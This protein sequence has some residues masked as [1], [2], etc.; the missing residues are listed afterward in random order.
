[1]AYRKGSWQSGE[2]DADK[3]ARHQSTDRPSEFTCRSITG[4][5]AHTVGSAKFCG[6]HMHEAKWDDVDRALAIADRDGV[7]VGMGTKPRTAAMLQLRLH[8]SAR[9]PSHAG[10]TANPQ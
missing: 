9:A 2:S 1:M 4:C 6:T 10:P 3:R 7:T 8:Q 5:H